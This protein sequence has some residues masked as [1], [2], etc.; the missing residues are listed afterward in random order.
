[1]K[2]KNEHEA[3]NLETNHTESTGIELE[4]TDIGTLLGWISHRLSKEGNSL[5]AL[6]EMWFDKGEDKQHVF[7]EFGVSV[8]TMGEQ[9]LAIRNQICQTCQLKTV[10][11]IMNFKPNDEADSK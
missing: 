5:Q 1:M 4:N 10:N 11:I 7:K 9:L 3:K 6:A 8:S 2:K